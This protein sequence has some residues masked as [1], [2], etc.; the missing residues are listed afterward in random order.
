MLLHAKVGVPRNTA[1]A[2][3][4]EAWFPNHRNIVM[5]EGSDAAFDA[6]SRDEVD[7]T[8]ASVYKLLALTNFREG[9]GY[10]SNVFV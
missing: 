7:M 6:L 9:T 5:Y 8:I 3:A 2:E 10:K 4:F 1:Y